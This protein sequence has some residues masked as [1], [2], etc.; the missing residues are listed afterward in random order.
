MYHYLLQI[1]MPTYRTMVFQAVSLV[2][3]FQVFE[4]ANQGS[5][6]SVDISYCTVLLV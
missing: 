2:G 5:N 3:G 6:N 4:P 1:L